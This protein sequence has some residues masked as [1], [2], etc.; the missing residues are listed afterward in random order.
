VPRC[1]GTR[2]RAASQCKPT[3]LAT[4]TYVG[5][6]LV[7]L[8][9]L[10]SPAALPQ[11]D[12]P[13]GP[14]HVLVLIGQEPGHTTVHQR[15]HLEGETDATTRTIAVPIGAGTHQVSDQDRRPLDWSQSAP[16]ILHVQIP[17]QTTALD[18]VSRDLHGPAQNQPLRFGASDAAAPLWLVIGVHPELK[19]EAFDQ[20]RTNIQQLQEAQA[21]PPQWPLPPDWHY[22]WNQGQDTHL[23]ESIEATHAELRPTVAPW[24]LAAGLAALLALMT[25][26]LVVRIHRGTGDPTRTKKQPIMKHLEE[27]RKRLTIVLIVL[28]IGTLFF[29]SFGFRWTTIAGATLPLPWPTIHNNA[30]SQVFAWLAGQIVPAGVQ[31]VVVAPFEAVITL[32]LLSTALGVLVAF[33]ILFY[34]AYAFLAPALYPHERRLVLTAV[35]AIIV[36][37]AAGAAFGILLMAPLIVMVLYGFAGAAGAIAFLTMPQLVGIAALLA[38]IFA[39]AFQLP[40]VMMITARMGL[41]RAATYKQK[42]RWAVLVIVIVSALVT[43]PTIITQLIVAAVLTTLYGIGLLLAYAADRRRIDAPPTRSTETD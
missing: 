33:P 16:G 6:L 5:A 23:P 25:L 8:L 11:Q 10:S 7:L 40:L 1:F 17:P 39:I 37:F 36:L 35:P 18:I 20:S 31:I 12:A 14:R 42:W 15:V 13:D 27:L 34:H 3:P 22:A 21:V 2:D 24:A 43:D 41:V 30:A 26:W 32:I 38:L 28:F 19:I 29:F 4:G 9:I